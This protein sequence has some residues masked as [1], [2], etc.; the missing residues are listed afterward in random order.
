MEARRTNTDAAGQ[1]A[2]PDLRG[3]LQWLAATD[4]LAVA[5]KGLS[6]IDEVAAVAK[7]L[8]NE[9]AVLFPSPG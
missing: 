6:L 4:R 5:R 1:G 7:K 3:W 2:H 8:E 9:R